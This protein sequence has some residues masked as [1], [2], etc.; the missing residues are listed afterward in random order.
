MAET[1]QQIADDL[2]ARIDSGEFAPGKRLPGEPALV[3]QYGVAKMTA[4]SALKILVAEG[5]AQ[6]RT[7]SG[8]YVRE[9]KP[10]IRDAVKRL[11]QSQWGS[12]TSIWSADIEDR[13]LDVVDVEVDEIEAPAWVARALELDEGSA[14][15]RRSRR[16]LVEGEPIQSA[17][18]YLPAD[19]VRDTPIAQPDS[20]PGGTF[21]RLE[22]IGSAPKRFEEDLR[23]RMPSA[24]EAEKLHLPAATPVLEVYRT[25]F[26]SDG[27][28]VEIN[29]MLLDAGAYVM[30]YRF[31]S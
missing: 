6:A 5:I 20:G 28:P 3:R 1:A 10:V 8:T 17:V 31:E 13:P 26:T 15:I 30:R 19:L 7:G 25:A 14:V 2:R 22:E 29:R 4:N 9:F 18:S 24:E 12:G 16:F 23:A 21:K 27:R 11:A